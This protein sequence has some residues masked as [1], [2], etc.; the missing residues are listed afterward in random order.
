LVHSDRRLSINQAYYVE[1]WSSY[2]KLCIEKGLNFG[3][4]IGFSTITMPQLTR[5]SLSSTFWPKN[6]NGIPTLFSWF[7]SKWL[8]ALSKNKVCLEGTKTLKK[9][10]NSTESYSTTGVPKMFPTVAALL[11]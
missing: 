3:P 6:Q 7:G 8:L 4:T 9:S 10:D 5:H 2:V 11:G 1:Y